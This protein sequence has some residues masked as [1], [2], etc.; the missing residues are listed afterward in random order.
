MPNLPS[1]Y[2]PTCSGDH[3]DCGETAIVPGHVDRG[4]F[5]QT[6][7]DALTYDVGGVE[8]VA[9]KRVRNFSMAARIEEGYGAGVFVVMASDG[10][11]PYYCG[12]DFEVKVSGSVSD[13]YEYTSTTC[14]FL[15]TRYGHGLFREV[16]EK[17]TLSANAASTALRYL[18]TW[19]VAY[20]AKFRVEHHV[21]E[22]TTTDFI[23]VGGEKV[24]LKTVT[25]TPRDQNDASRP[26]I[27]VWP[28]PP[29]L[30]TFEDDDIA[31]F[32]FY[33][34][35]AGGEDS[36]RTARDGGKDY[37]RTDWMRAIGK[38]Y[39]DADQAEADSRYLTYHLGAGE[40][41][42]STTSAR[43]IL[44]S[45]I[46]AGSIAVDGEGNILYSVTVGDEVKNGLIANPAGSLTELLP[47][48][49]ALMPVGVVA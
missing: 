29:S 43:D 22:I 20:Y 49:A 5:S 44:R 30:G 42:T 38:A 45:S 40:P 12:A 16:K 10:V 14:F 33:D 23:V 36:G 8:I 28:N 31:N 4:G 17:I 3:F 18:G 11:S 46:P 47:D 35:N 25:E 27:L 26:L 34:Y 6:L 19:G 21:L 13:S 48:I 7:N 41:A 39:E 9:K 24:V 37:Y 1:P 32:G 2:V 15:D